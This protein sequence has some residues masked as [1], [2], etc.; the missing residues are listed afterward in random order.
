MFIAATHDLTSIAIGAIAFAFALPFVIATSLF[1]LAFAETI[2][3]HRLICTTIMP[4]MNTFGLY[5]L[6]PWYRPKKWAYTLFLAYLMAAP[7]VASLYIW[8]IVSQP[9][10]KA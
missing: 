10:W 1:C 9:R 2:L 8:P 6:V 3:R 7:V 5:V 4:A